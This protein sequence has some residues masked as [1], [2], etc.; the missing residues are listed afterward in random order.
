MANRLPPPEY[1]MAALRAGRYK[2]EQEKDTGVPTI[3]Q[4]T[5]SS[6][7]A[8]KMQE[9]ANASEFATAANRN[10]KYF[11]APGGFLDKLAAFDQRQNPDNRPPAT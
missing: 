2:K 9:V 5:P 6:T 8:M 7:P 4:G 10:G 1:V 3:A 11:F